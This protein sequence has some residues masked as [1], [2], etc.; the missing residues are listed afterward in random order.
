MMTPNVSL[1][2]VG[3]IYQIKNTLND[4]V[5]VGRTICFYKRCHQ[6]IYDFTNERR[7]CVNDH[8]SSSIKKYGIDNFTFEVLEICEKSL[9]EERELWWMDELDSCERGSG[10]NLRRDSGGCM[11]V[12]DS[13]RSK[14]S[15]TIGEQ[16]RD[17]QRDD[18]SEK[19][20]KSWS[21]RPDDKRKASDRFRKTLTKYNYEITQGVDVFIV[22]Y[23]GLVGLGYKNVVSKFFSKKTDSVDFKGVRIRRFFVNEN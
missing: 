7:K 9:M 18:H 20:V 6:H 21:S 1:K 12:H 15:I 5:Y 17:G 19:M 3:G 14:I 2:G 10:Y 11:I 22:D 8:L 16:W 13:T 23:Q 4:K